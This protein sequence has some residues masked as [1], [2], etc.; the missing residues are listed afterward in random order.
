MSHHPNPVVADILD[1]LRALYARA[2]EAS[3]PALFEIQRE[4][5][6]TRARLLEIPE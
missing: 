5:R 1:E 4:I 2:R 6:E 3:G